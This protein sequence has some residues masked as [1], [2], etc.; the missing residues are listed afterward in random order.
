MTA[1]AVTVQIEA[2]SP[3]DA[4]RIAAGWTLTPDALVLSIVGTPEFAPGLPVRADD[5][6]RV[7]LIQPR[8]T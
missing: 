8:D 4:A 2:D 1:F 3:A 5:K 6:G 7:P